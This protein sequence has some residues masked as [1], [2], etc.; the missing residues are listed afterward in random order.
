MKSRKTLLFVIGIIVSALVVTAAVIL[1][2]KNDNAKDSTEG[3][4]IT[5]DED[6][7]KD[8][9]VDGSQLFDDASDTDNSE[10]QSN[11]GTSSNQNSMGTG[12]TQDDSDNTEEDSFGDRTPGEEEDSNN[13]N[14]VDDEERDKDAVEWTPNY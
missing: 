14:K 11:V 7:D 9:V 12:S 1:I 6:L 3:Q 8:N 10:S 13:D 2:R 5:E 4:Y